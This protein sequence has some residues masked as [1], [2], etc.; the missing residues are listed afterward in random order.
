MID[1]L[2]TAAKDSKPT[3]YWLL[4]FELNRSNY[5]FEWESIEMYKATSH[6]SEIIWPCETTT[7]PIYMYTCMYD[8]QRTW[9]KPNLLIAQTLV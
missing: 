9:F 5:I 2:Q 3:P 7:C 8:K 1:K 6:I 4:Y